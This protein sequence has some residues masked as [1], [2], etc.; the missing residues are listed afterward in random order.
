VLP[1][2]PVRINPTLHV[3]I[4]GDHDRV[5]TCSLCSTLILVGYLFYTVGGIIGNAS[6]FSSLSIYL[7]R[8]NKNALGYD[9]IVRWRDGFLSHPN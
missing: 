9:V 6:C 1:R 5:R 3:I 7:L 8:R 2:Y 4:L